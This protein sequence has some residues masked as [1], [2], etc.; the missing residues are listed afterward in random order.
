MIARC[1]QVF[2]LRPFHAVSKSWSPSSNSGDTCND[3]RVVSTS[4]VV[5]LER[6]PQTQGYCDGPACG[7]SAPAVSSGAVPAGVES[8]P[9]GTDSAITTEHL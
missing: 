5:T 3:D 6:S 4:A 1:W 8:F 9:N 2:V 7:Q